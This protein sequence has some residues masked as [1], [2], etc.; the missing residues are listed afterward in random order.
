MLFSFFLEWMNVRMNEKKIHKGKILKNEKVANELFLIEFEAPSVENILAGQFVSIL[1]GS[2][3]LRRPFSVAAFDYEKKVVSVYFKRKGEGTNYLSSLKNGDEIDFIGAM[4]NTFDLTEKK[5]LIIGAGVGFAPVFYLAENLQNKV[6]VGAFTSVNDM[7]KNL[8]P[9]YV[10]TNDGS[11]GLKGSVLDYLDEI[12]DK[13]KPEIIYSCGPLVVLKAI[14]QKGVEKNIETQIALEKIMACSVGVCR[15]CVIK[16]K[17]ENGEI[18]NKAVCKNG[19]VFSGK[20]I[21][22]D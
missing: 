1:C 5:S 10:I 7:P 22:W 2:L 9:D 21:V 6:T 8:T 16:V 15:G 3:T 11:K 12:I 19:P 17:D 18:V 13:E 4:G 14:S 20:D